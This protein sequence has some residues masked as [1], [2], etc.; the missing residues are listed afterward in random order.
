MIGISW[1]VDQDHS[2]TQATASPKLDTIYE[3][4][5]RTSSEPGQPRE[6]GTQS[7]PR[8]IHEVNTPGKT[9]G[10]EKETKEKNTR[11]NNIEYQQEDFKAKANDDYKKVTEYFLP[12]KQ[13][14]NCSA[15]VNI[16]PGRITTYKD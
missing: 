1:N 12:D 8:Q 6:A 13:G 3:S 4:S 10:K 9:G 2:G 7:Q 15:V 16:C 11:K 5:R 14:C